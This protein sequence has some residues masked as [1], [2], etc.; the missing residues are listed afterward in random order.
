[1]RGGIGR[2]LWQ[3]AAGIVQAVRAA[4]RLRLLGKPAAAAVAALAVTGLSAAV[5]EKREGNL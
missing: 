5:S 4:G 1:M 2:R 3:A